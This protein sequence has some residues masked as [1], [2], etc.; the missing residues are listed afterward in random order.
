MNDT[1]TEPFDPLSVAC[2]RHFSAGSGSKGFFLPM[3]HHVKIAMQH[4]R[5]KLAARLVLFCLADHADKTG[6]CYPSIGTLKRETNL[7]ERGVQDGLKQLTELGDVAIHKNAGVKGVNVYEFTLLAPA[8]SAPPQNLHPRSSCA[9]PPQNFP[10][11]PAE[12]APKAPLSTKEPPSETGFAFADWFRKFLPEKINLVSG[13]R[14]Q[15]AET[16]D[17]MVRLDGRTKDEIKSVCEWA[18][19]D[20]FWANQFHSPCKL[21]K[22]NKDGILFFD[23]FA[24]KLNKSA[25]RAAIERPMVFETPIQKQVREFRGRE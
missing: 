15:W 13:W 1:N 21:R 22:R 16:Y 18:K 11:T 25:P 10:K 8:E 23:L 20:S 2:V 14:V 24:G 9:L 3:I 6:R 12:S 7:S 17:S 19:A 4:S 5:S